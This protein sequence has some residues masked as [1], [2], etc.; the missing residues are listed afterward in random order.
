MDRILVTGGSGFIGTN[1]LISLLKER[2]YILLNIDI[3]PSPVE[4]IQEITELCDIRD[5]D[6]IEALISKFAPDYI[7]HLAARTD[8]NGKTLSD[9]S[10]NTVG[11]KNIVECAKKLPFL[12]RILITSSMLVC[13][14]GYQPT[15][16][17]D[18]CPSTIYGESKVE[19]ERITKDANLTC[20]WGFLR[21]TSIWG[22]WFKVPY[23]TF[24]DMVR[25]GHYFHIGHKSCTKTYGYVGNAVYQIKSILFNNMA[26]RQ[27]EVYYLGDNPTDIEE[28][29]NEIAFE[30]N[31]T[32]LRMP[33][34]LIKMAALVGDTLGVCGISFPMTSF[35][36]KNM[37]TDN[38][39]N[40]ST[41]DIVAPNRPYTRIEGI[42]ETLSWLDS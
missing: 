1:L 42:K 7:V 39:V 18:Y 24:F 25:A 32:I 16:E 4:D 41:T 27:G 23:R 36:L 38:V 37:T 35:R 33:Y 31:R 13:K 10:S 28:W 26:A 30:D 19:T 5:R 8:L 6:R 17:Y 12:K 15:S 34:G 20:S 14:V 22:P 3:N 29:A 40:L 11:V 9:Y 21:P 2:K